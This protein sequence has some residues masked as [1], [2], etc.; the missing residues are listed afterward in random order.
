MRRLRF[1]T[2]ATLSLAL[3]LLPCSS[4]GEAFGKALGSHTGHAAVA[5]RGYVGH[6]QASAP[7]DPSEHESSCCTDCSAWL[8]PGSDDNSVAI[9]THNWSSSDL[10]PIALIHASLIAG[11]SARE[12]RFR[13]MSVAFVDGT[14]VYAKTQRYRI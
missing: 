4:F 13:L 3:L 7:H 2:V 6:N 11:K 14:R 1:A 9:I 8:E 5:A 10:F 12:H